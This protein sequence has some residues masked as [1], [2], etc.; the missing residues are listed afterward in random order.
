MLLNHYNMNREHRFLQ[1]MEI[2]RDNLR[3]IKISQDK[4]AASQGE[5]DD[6]K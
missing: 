4:A 6:R 3:E 5:A 2:M 1:I